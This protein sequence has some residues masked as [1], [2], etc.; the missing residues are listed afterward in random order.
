MDKVILQSISQLTT[1]EGIS[2]SSSQYEVN[3]AASPRR[4]QV[5]VTT[6][7]LRES[8]ST[9]VILTGLVRMGWTDM[10]SVLSLVLD[11]NM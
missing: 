5:L 3:L 4:S 2:P 11:T 9:A 10:A 6:V 1:L 8:L 7:E